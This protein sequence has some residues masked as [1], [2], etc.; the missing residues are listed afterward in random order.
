MDT[1]DRIT[2]TANRLFYTQGYNNTGINQIIK[3]AEVAKSSL[4]Q[5]FP[6]KEDLLVEY[7]ESTSLSTNSSLRSI[8]DKHIQPREKILAIFDFLLDFSIQTEFQGCNFQNI[9]AEIPQEDGRIRALI[10]NQ[11]NQVRKLF[12]DI[13]KP[14]GKENLADE[15]SVLFDGAMVA[16]KIFKEL[17]PIRSTRKMVEKLL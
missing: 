11:K 14:I 2:T 15:L 13:L 10:R 8:A 6:S 17:W 3:E 9:A 16:S 7:L 12:A 1:R 4:Y 5:Y